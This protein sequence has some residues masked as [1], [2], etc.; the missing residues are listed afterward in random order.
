MYKQ[1][2]N[3]FPSI[4]FYANDAK[5]LN[6][7]YEWFLGKDGEYI[8]IA[9]TEL[10]EKD[11]TL[12]ATFL[13][14]VHE[15]FPKLTKKEQ[16]WKQL[17]HYK[18]PID[19]QSFQNIEFRLIYFQFPEQSMEPILF[20]DA[21]KQ[22]FQND[23]IVLW[24]SNDSGVLIE[25]CQPNTEQLSYKEIIHVLMSDLY[26][27]L[28]FLI[29]PLQTNILDAPLIYD[30]ISRYAPI[31]FKYD[32]AHVL[33][34]LDALPVFIIEN[35]DRELLQKLIPNE[36]NCLQN[37]HELRQMVQTLIECNLNI[38]HAAKQLFV[39]RNSL[40]YRLDKFSSQTGLDIRHV[41]DAFIV[42]LALMI[43]D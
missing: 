36:L 35:S 40:Q 33:T 27:K 21:M 26:V 16:W 32:N 7:D 4:C 13:K 9:K 8:G 1:L 6:D 19:T 20:K 28:R 24:E 2:K 3:I 43:L 14:P 15:Y 17:L 31:A 25:E 10:T 38:T 39:H 30:Q 12:L 23:V 5:T 42:Y 34:F 22:L 11:C 18:Q 41:H 29:G 37:N